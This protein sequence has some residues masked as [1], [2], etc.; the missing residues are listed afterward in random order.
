MVL[1]SINPTH[2]QAWKKLTTHFNTTQSVTMQDLFANDENRV[3]KF[4]I[5]WESFLVDYSKN[6][7]DETTIKLLLELA[8]ETGLKNAIN[9][10]F[11]GSKIN[12]T[13]DRA[14]LH[15]ALRAAKDENILVNDQNIIPEIFDVKNKIKIFCD[16]VIS[17]DKKGYTNKT[18]TD[19]VNIGIGGSDLGPAM[20]VEALQ[21]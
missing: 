18:F 3:N 5:Q 11:I 17:G 9:S 7:I 13:E 15:T 6:R 21:K 4:N 19:I 10:Y 14:V 8:E 12:Q 1:Q 16:S 20:V 2:T